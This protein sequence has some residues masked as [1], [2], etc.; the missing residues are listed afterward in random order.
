ML[1]PTLTYAQATLSNMHNKTCVILL[2]GLFRTHKS[3]RKLS[4]YLH[5]QGYVIVNKTYPSTKLPIEAIANNYLPEM[6]ATCHQLGA[7]KIH[8]VTH[9][10]GGIVLR[11]YLQNHSL[12]NLGRIVMLSPPNH[13]SKIA[14]YF[15]KL[16]LFKWLF[17]P[18]GQELSSK[19][20]SFVNQLPASLGSFEVGI[21]TGNHILFP[22]FN[23][24]IKA[25]ND[26]IVSIKTTQLDNIKDF[27]VLGTTHAFMIYN[28]E[29][30][31]QTAYF[32]KNGNFLH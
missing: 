2:H 21:I 20:S 8:F 32:F 14:D 7:R 18:A 15:H 27:I 5:K 19:K 30:L 10:M 1:C 28:K 3:M 16:R 9:S 29:V 11:V 13:G 23:R 24:I 26:G 31:K 22:P 4:D 17:G 6:I 12:S 25:P